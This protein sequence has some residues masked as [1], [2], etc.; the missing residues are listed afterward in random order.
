MMPRTMTRERMVAIA[1]TAMA[2]ADVHDAR[3]IV[4]RA[5]ALVDLIESGG[6]TTTADGRRRLTCPCCGRFAT[7]PATRG[8][9][10]A[11]CGA[12]ACHRLRRGLLVARGQG[13]TWDAQDLSIAL[14]DAAAA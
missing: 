4:A 3:R 12:E 13:W 10:R 7:P 14:A 11:T 1:Q 5:R 9:P 8:K 6:H 2:A